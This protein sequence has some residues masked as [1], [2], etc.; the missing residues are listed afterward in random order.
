MHLCILKFF[1]R[2][3]DLCR[4]CTL[5]FAINQCSL[6]KLYTLTLIII[7]N[8]KVNVAYVQPNQ[9]FILLFIYFTS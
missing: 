3:S 4:L 9:W 7:V 8:I 5:F 1:L 6:R 2:I